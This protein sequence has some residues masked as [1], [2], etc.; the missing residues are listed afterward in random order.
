M[1][2]W[3]VLM[4]GLLLGVVQAVELVDADEAE[5]RI[6]EG[7]TQVLDVRTEAEWKEGLSAFHEQRHADYERFW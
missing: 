7:K 4:T 1:R 3:I 5:K 2:T 6:A